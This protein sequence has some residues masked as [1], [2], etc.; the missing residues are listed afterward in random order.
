MDHL[1]L[2]SKVP[3]HSHISS[4]HHPF[5]LPGAFFVEL[6]TE[7]MQRFVITEKVP[8]RAFSW[9]KASNSAFTFNT[10]LRHYAKNKCETHGK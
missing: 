8:T 2:G 3:K 4:Y 9:L 5:P 6:E 10:L 1:D 7:D